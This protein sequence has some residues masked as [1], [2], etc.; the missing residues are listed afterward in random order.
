MLHFI[1]AAAATATEP[2]N[3]NIYEDDPAYME[4]DNT[5][6][7]VT[8]WLI[9]VLICIFVIVLNL[10]FNQ[11]TPRRRWTKIRTEPA[12]GIEAHQRRVRWK[13]PVVRKYQ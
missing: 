11:P 12:I 8:V 3:S 5:F 13:T 4:Q 1:S 9:S 10:F 2:P 7:W 6:S